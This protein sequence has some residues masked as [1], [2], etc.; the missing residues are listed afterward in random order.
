[1]AWTEWIIDSA[2]SG[3]TSDLTSISGSGFQA[4]QIASA[5]QMN[6]ITR[7]ANIITVAFMKALNI[8]GS[9][10][11]SIG[12][13][14]SGLQKDITDGI[15]AIKVNAAGTADTAINAQYASSDHTKGTIEDRLTSL[16]FKKATVSSTLFSGYLIRQGNLVISSR[17]DVADASSTILRPFLKVN[18]GVYT[19]AAMNDYMAWIDDD[20]FKGSCYT[21]FG[22][23]CGYKVSGDSATYSGIIFGTISIDYDSN[24]QKSFI[25]FSAPYVMHNGSMVTP[26][27][28]TISNAYC[29]LCYRVN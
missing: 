2:V 17:D 15:K 18:G 1:M 7:Q 22:L 4:N 29:A 13:S 16:G 5:K 28:F 10:A 6:S 9:Y 26:V 11:S 23:N 8:D 12:S 27:Q 25:T 21:N 24:V 19:T 3:N 20:D 14:S